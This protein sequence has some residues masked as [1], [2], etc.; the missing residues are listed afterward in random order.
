MSLSVRLILRLGAAATMG[1][2]MT[3]GGFASGEE[4]FVAPISPEMLQI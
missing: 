1:I 4:F 2:N 3:V